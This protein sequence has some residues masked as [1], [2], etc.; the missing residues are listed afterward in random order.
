[1]AAPT[2]SLA[3][4]FQIPVVGLGTW[5]CDNEEELENSLNAALECGYRHIDTAFLYRNEHVVGR[6]I[7]QWISNGKLTRE[8]L[9]VTTKLPSE[10][11][12]PDLV[13]SYLKKQLES[14]QLAY[15]DLYLIHF[16]IGMK[17]R[18]TP[19]EPLEPI[20]TDHVAVW[21][22]FEEQVD[23][24]RT[25]TIG[26]SNFNIKQ[27]ERILKIARI[28]PASLQVENHV[29]LQQNDLV[30]YAQD[31]GIVVVGYSP[32][33]S[34]GIAKFFQKLNIEPKKVPSILDNETVKRIGQKYGKSPAQIALKFLLQRGIV[35]IPKSVTETRLKQNIDLFDFLLDENDLV[36]LRALDVGEEA[37]VCDF[38]FISSFKTHPEW[39]FTE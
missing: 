28:K 33:G 25:R 15:V 1:M 20:P 14:L 5:Q 27:I 17:P 2:V 10:A 13:E 16:P 23:Q 32:L 35:V 18:K 30:K 22:K 26:I 7:K 19:T 36:D 31:N 29:F 37:R 38:S 12:Q 21:K 11:L 6:V 4:K 39:P 9:F 24:G 34:P 3:E 8:Q